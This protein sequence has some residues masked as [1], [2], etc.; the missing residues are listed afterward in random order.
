MKLAEKLIYLRKE[1]RL[2]QLKLAELMNVSRQAVSRW[3]VGAATPSIENLKYLS[4]LYGVSLEYL[5]DEGEDSPEGRAATAA[6]AYGGLLEKKPGKRAVL[7]LTAAASCIFALGAGAAFGFMGLA[8]RES[9]GDTGGEINYRVYD[10]YTEMEPDG[11]IGGRLYGY[12]MAETD[13]GLVAGNVVDFAVIYP[14]GEVGFAVSH[15]ALEK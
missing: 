12:G 2:S 15:P 8:N 10:G 4:G 14:D 5:L 6:G 11:A 1:K 7:A 13:G 9:G 3:E